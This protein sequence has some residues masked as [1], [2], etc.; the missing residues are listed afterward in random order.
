MYKF[1]TVV[2]VPFPFTDLTSTKVRPA[3]VLSRADAQST[4]VILCFITSQLQERGKRG[5]FLIENT[6]KHFKASGLK[7][8]SLLRFDKLATLSK[9]LVLGE[10]GVLHKDIL[11][12]AKK[13]FEDVFGF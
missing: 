13:E 5:R 6:N 1:G 7:V 9:K 2:L 4:D 10:L 3:L 8:D 11:K 12:K